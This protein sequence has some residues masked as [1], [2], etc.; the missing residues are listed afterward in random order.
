M[1]HTLKNKN[2]ITAYLKLS[3]DIAN[4]NYL[5][6]TEL[7][8]ISLQVPS[9]WQCWN[10]ISSLS[11]FSFFQSYCLFLR[12]GKGIWIKNI[13]ILFSVLDFFFFFLA[14]TVDMHSQRYLTKIVHWCAWPVFDQRALNTFPAATESQRP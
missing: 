6:L 9:Y 1:Q 14:C 13:I 2:E 10:V 3:W 4:G 5:L 8:K 12:K 7:L 11:L